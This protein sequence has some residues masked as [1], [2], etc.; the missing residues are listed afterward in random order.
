M[1]LIVL[2]LAKTLKVSFVKY[3]KV[4]EILKAV[5]V[6]LNEYP[7]TWISSLFTICVM[8]I[9]GESDFEHQYG[10]IKYRNINKYDL[11]TV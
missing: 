8:Q 10:T 7:T 3:I 1:V 11:S 9:N 6:L 2:K 4:I 5:S